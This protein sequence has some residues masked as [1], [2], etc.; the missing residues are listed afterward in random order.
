MELEEKDLKERREKAYTP[1]IIEYEVRRKA[2]N[3]RKRNR[4]R[5]K[6]V[7]DSLRE[8]ETTGEHLREEKDRR[9]GG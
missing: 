9:E 3:E 5:N 4:E 8:R 1:R 6:S 2:R 7:K